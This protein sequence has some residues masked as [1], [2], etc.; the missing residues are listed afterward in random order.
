MENKDTMHNNKD[1][2]LEVKDLKK[3]FKSP[4]GTVHAVDGVNFTIR[5]GK[6]LGVVGE[7]GCGKST[8]GR[9]ILRLIEPTEGQV[10]FEGND[11][12]TADK[13]EMKALR[14]DL[15]IVFQD[16]YSSIN[17]RKTVLELIAEPIKFNNLIPG[18]SEIDIE[19]RVLELMQT[20]GIDERLINSYPHELDGGRRQRIGIARALAMKPKFIVCDEPVSALDVSIQAQVLNLLR[21]LQREMGLT[22]IFI[23][24]D[25]SVVNYFADD[26]MV[27][28]LGQVVEKA[29]SEELFAH[30]MHP[31][32]QALLSAILIPKVNGNPEQIKLR[33]EVTSPI[34]PPDEC[35]FAKRCNYV[36]EECRKSTPELLEVEPNHFVACHCIKPGGVNTLKET[37]V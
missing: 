14:K 11:I 29:P 37:V 17:P 18:G 9:C 30:P 13:K 12:C 34:D 27:M 33:G 5:R 20:V 22:Y 10:I 15:Q 21:K 25:L 7:S 24:H 23:T 3:Y 26:I 2:L 4:R 31:Y 1:I 6:T 28:Y 36:C 32:T 16:P 19:N 8:L 35:R